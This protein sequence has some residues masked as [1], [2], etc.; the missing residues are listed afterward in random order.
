[1]SRLKYIRVL[2][3]FV[4]VWLAVAPAYAQSSIVQLP[5]PNVQGGVGFG[6]SVSI[7]GNSAV[8]GL[9]GTSNGPVNVYARNGSGWTL[10][11]T[12]P[13]PVS[14]R[15]SYTLTGFG[16]VI[17]LDGDTIVAAAQ[18]ILDSNQGAV[19]GFYQVAVYARNGG[20]WNLE[21]QFD[22]RTAAGSDSPRTGVD[23]I[24]VSGN[25]VVVGA[26]ANNTTTDG[27]GAAYVYT[28]SGSYVATLNPGNLAFG[29][30]FGAAV[31]IQGQTVVV[32]ATDVNDARGYYPGAAFVFGQNA[33]GANKWGLLKKLSA[34]DSRGF[35]QF[36][37][38]AA[39]DQ[40]RVVVGSN[41]REGSAYLFERNR[42]GSN[43]WGLVKKLVES[44]RVPRSQGA[45]QVSVD[46]S[47]NRVLL[48]VVRIDAG[49]ANPP[50]SV[51]VFTEQSGSWV[52]A[53]RLNIQDNG[54]AQV[55]FAV[56]VSGDQAIIGAPGE[57]GGVGTAYVVALP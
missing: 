16:S 14:P 1:M 26:A 7:D 21:T 56:G 3:A 25:Q 45:T 8:V 12:L 51:A 38:S 28:R 32:G 22:P 10:A 46:I 44:T 37:R 36:G 9:N 35:E 50:G 29:D 47:G 40:D 34:P 42:G 20:S 43:K 18:F 27:T 54:S 17:A 13:L 19:D 24:A 39:V 41:S 15:P 11:A 31:A 57:G 48:G 52:L 2:L 55:G 6:S 5:A 33:G 53:T 23:S 4:F 49:G 30:L